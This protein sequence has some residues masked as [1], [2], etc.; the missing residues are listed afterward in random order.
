MQYFIFYPIV[1]S[2]AAKS[3]VHLKKVQFNFKNVVKCRSRQGGERQRRCVVVRHFANDSY[4][5][6]AAVLLKRGSEVSHHLLGHDLHRLLLQVVFPDEGL[7]GQH[8][9]SGTVWCRADERRRRVGQVD[10]LMWGATTLWSNVRSCCFDSYTPVGMI[11]F[12]IKR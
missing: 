11:H 12:I 7:A 10:E 1:G 3:V 2:N 6:N 9:C 8:R 5:L 4:H